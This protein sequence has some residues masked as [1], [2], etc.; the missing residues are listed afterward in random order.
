V[1]VLLQEFS[2]EAYLLFAVP[3]FRPGGGQCTYVRSTLH[4]YGG[5]S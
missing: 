2:C 4:I 3:P 1:H 5:G